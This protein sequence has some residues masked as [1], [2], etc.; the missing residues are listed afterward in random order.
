MNIAATQG[1]PFPLV[2]PSFISTFA[3]PSMSS[4][5]SSA[6]ASSSFALGTSQGVLLR[7]KCTYSFQMIARKSAMTKSSAHHFYRAQLEEI[8]YKQIGTAVDNVPRK[9]GLSPRLNDRDKCAIL[10]TIKNLQ[11][12]HCNFT[13]MQFAAEAGIDPN[14]AHRRTL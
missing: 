12:T 2:V 14:V 5:S 8:T 1:R 7:K 9:G 10:R 11:K 3:S 4:A 13:V 6:L